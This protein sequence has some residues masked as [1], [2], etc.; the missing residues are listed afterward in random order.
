M[1]VSP[2][3]LAAKAAELV[4]QGN[5]GVAYTY[6]EPLIGYSMSKTAPPWSMSR[7]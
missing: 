4:P 5:I 7:A 1:E 3:Q 6:N 2:E